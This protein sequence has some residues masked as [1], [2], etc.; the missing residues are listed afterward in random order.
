MG[1]E[2]VVKKGKN[3]VEMLHEILRPFLLRQVKSDA[4]VERIGYQVLYPRLKVHSHMSHTLLCSALFEICH[5]SPTGMC[6]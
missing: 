6:S 1:A 5:M 3:V 4:P 2:E